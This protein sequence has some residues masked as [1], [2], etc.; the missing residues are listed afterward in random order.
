MKYHFSK[1]VKRAMKGLPARRSR[2]IRRE[3]IE[4]LKTFGILAGYTLAFM[5][6]CLIY[7]I[8]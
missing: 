5:A 4:D 2:R 7:I 8:I 6:A 1:E 3:T